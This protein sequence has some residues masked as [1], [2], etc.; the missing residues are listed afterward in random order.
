MCSPFFFDAALSFYVHSL[1][2]SKGKTILIY[3][4]TGP[5]LVIKGKNGSKSSVFMQNIQNT[6]KK[7]ET[8][9]KQERWNLT[10]PNNEKKYL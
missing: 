3:V 9:W 4:Q 8:T 6:A 5:L 1:L 7:T 2:S 10:H